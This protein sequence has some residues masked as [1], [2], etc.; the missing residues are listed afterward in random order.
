M[1]PQSI[2][3]AHLH[4]LRSVPD[5]RVAMCERVMKKA[6]GLGIVMNLDAAHLFWLH[7]SREIGKEWIDSFHSEA[8]EDETLL[9]AFAAI[10]AF[11]GRYSPAQL[12]LYMEH[13]DSEKVRRLVELEMTRMPPGLIEAMLQAYYS[14]SPQ[15]AIYLALYLG[16]KPKDI[17][18]RARALDGGDGM[19][20]AWM[21]K[22]CGKRLRQPHVKRYLDANWHEALDVEE[23]ARILADHLPGMDGYQNWLNRHGKSD[24]VAADGDHPGE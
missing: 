5:H 10:G 1:N 9:N 8:A 21:A 13:L 4:S 15:P 22:M 11:D 7:R 19:A 3:D 12:Q 24:H 20:I 6:R 14:L 17:A 23:R 2:F 18:F 16:T